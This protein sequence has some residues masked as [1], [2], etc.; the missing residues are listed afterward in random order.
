MYNW[1]AELKRGRTS[2]KDD[3]HPGHS[4]SASAPKIVNLSQRNL[5]RSKKNN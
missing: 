1:V 2:L 4:K 5:K 3:P